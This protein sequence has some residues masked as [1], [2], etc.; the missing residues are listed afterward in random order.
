MSGQ[1]R[2]NGRDRKNTNVWAVPGVLATLVA[3]ASAFGAWSLLLPVLPTAV[4]EHGG[5]ATL[6]GGT[7]G[8]FMAA[9]VATQV[10]TPWMLR[11]F[12]YRPVMAVAAFML[13]VPALGH[14]LGMDAWIVLLFS[15]LR[16][17]GFGAITVAQS[18]L[19]AELVP[20]RLLGKATGLIGVFI[21]LSQMVG[22]PLG[23]FLADVFGYDAVFVVAAVVASVAAVMCLRI[24]AL[25]ADPVPLADPGAD[26]EPTPMWKLV[27]VPALALL[28]TSMSFGA[29]SSFLPA[30]VE[31]LDSAAG[32]VLGGF[33][34]SIVGAASLVFRY[35]V[36]VAADRSGQPGRLLI[37]SQLLALSG[38]ALMTATV[39]FGWPVWL[40][41]LAALVFGG[42][43]GAVQNESLLTM[44]QRTPRSKL[45]EASAVWNIFFDAGTGLGSV[46]FGAVASVFLFSGAFGAGAAVI[47]F[48]LFIT[49]ADQILGIRRGRVTPVSFGRPRRQI[50][51]GMR[52]NRRP[53]RPRF[54]RPGRK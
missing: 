2:P 11:R 29:V 13:G 12:G 28:T 27:V 47:V 6:A 7:T 4:L 32:S 37:P 34:L 39:V 17:T 1:A 51:S 49:G 41:V 19:V 50:T 23:L 30:A 35:L 25:K 20:P 38:M 21:G 45:S 43:F 3:V 46:L 8:I 31:S 53:R 54:T 10:A 44:F 24:P 33:M 52:R 18:A 16:G 9:T 5:S 15:A 22:L 42:G 40:L 26:H 14:T 36:G 48:G